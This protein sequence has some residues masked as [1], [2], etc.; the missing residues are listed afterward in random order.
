MTL[1]LEN[2]LQLVAPTNGV[3]FIMTINTP[4][5]GTKNILQVTPAHFFAAVPIGSIYFNDVVGAG[6]QKLDVFAPYITDKQI[7][8]PKGLIFDYSSYIKCLIIKLTKD[9]LYNNTFRYF[10]VWVGELEEEITIPRIPTF[11]SRCKTCLNN[12]M[13]VYET[14]FT[15][16]LDQ[17]ERDFIR[18][19]PELFP[20]QRG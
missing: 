19:N 4:K 20:T 5:F 13:K 8:L 14:N 18:D 15:Q 16:Y 1:F 6:Y 9:R 3:D 10:P 7:N 2:S 12:A 11:K 17:Y